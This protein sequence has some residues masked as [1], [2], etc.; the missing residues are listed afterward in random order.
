MPD[1][2]ITPL[3]QSGRPPCS[4]PLPDADLKLGNANWTKGLQAM[5]DWIWSGNLNPEAFPN[6]LARYF[7]QIPGVFEQQ[8]AFSTTL[9]F[10]EPSFRNGV[11]VSGFI[12]RPVREL[13]INLT[14]QRRHAWY[15]MTHH[16]ILS[17]LTARKHGIPDKVFANKLVHLTEHQRHV[18]ST[19]RSSGTSSSSL[20][21]SRPIRSNGAT[22]TATR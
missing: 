22:A 1:S 16:A 9:I 13:V 14:G 8:L 18:T 17:T 6:N 7:L 10:D 2:K 3:G 20:T 11:Q 4:I 21:H 12:E 15:T 5:S 19:P